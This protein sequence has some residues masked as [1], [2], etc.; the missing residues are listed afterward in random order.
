MELINIKYTYLNY[1]AKIKKEYEY[2]E[3]HNN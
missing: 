3:I 1:A 2:Y